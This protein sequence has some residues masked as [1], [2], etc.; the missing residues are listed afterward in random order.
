MPTLPGTT[1]ATVAAV[2]PLFFRRVWGHARVLLAGAVLAPARRTVSAALRVAGLARVA[3]ST[4]TPGSSA[5]PSGPG[6]PRVRCCCAC[7]RRPSLLPAR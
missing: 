2:A 6:W 3:R 5:V 1:V 7:R 4:A